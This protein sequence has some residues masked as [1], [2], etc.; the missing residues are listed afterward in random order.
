VAALPAG[1]APPD[2][3]EYCWEV[4]ERLWREPRNVH[5]WLCRGDFNG[6]GLT[7]VAVDLRR[8]TRV[9][10][11]AL[12]GRADGSFSLHWVSEPTEVGAPP[13]HTRTEFLLTR[14][15]DTIDY[16]DEGGVEPAARAQGGIER[17]DL[18]GPIV[19]Y[20]WDD[21]RGAYSAFRKAG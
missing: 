14:A 15:S 6:D 20:Y 11:A 8:L 12:H 17:A 7:D 13:R 10:T 9:G 2:R 4:R 1:W 21:E 18:D 19:L 5:P 3:E 16:R